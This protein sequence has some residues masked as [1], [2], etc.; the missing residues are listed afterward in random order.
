MQYVGVLKTRTLRKWGGTFCLLHGRH[1]VGFSFL[2][3]F[4]WFS[5]ANNGTC[6]TWCTM[7]S[8]HGEW[9]TAKTYR[10]DQSVSFGFKLC[11][12]GGLLA[13]SGWFSAKKTICAA[14]SQHKNN[15]TYIAKMGKSLEFHAFHLSM[16][17]FE[18]LHSTE[19]V[20][21]TFRETFLIKA[22]VCCN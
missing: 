8:D 2:V 15:N 16:F 13:R 18:E 17:T 3:A 10:N 21:F 12:L 5:L 14:L 22:T 9:N 6:C 1:S 19:K 20:L 11:S 4:N 7:F